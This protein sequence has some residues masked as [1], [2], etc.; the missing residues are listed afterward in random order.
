[1]ALTADPSERWRWKISSCCSW[2]NAA[3]LVMCQYL[4]KM[5]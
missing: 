2:D 3:G 4:G 1:L 5:T